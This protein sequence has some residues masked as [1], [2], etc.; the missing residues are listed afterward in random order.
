MRD[1]KK[2]GLR[3]AVALLVIFSL[4][5]IIPRAMPGDP[6]IYLVG[7]DA[8]LDSSTMM[9]L[10][11][12]LGLDKPLW[13]QYLDYWRQVLQLDFGYSYHFK[14]KVSQVILKRIPWTLGLLLPPL[15][16]G[17]ILGTVLGGLSG[18]R[19]NNWLNKSLTGCSLAI[20]STP[21][22]FLALLLLYLFSIHWEIFPLKGFY[23]TGTF[24]DLLGHYFLPVLV[25]TLFTASRNF[26]IM[27]GSVLR[28]K[29]QWYVLYARA[30]GLSGN[31]LFFRH[32][33]RNAVLPAITMIALD[34]GFLLS[35]ALLVEIVFSM[36][37]MGTLI[38]EA[39]LSR[40]YPLLQGIF[41]VITLMVV[42]ANLAADLLYRRLDPRLQNQ[43]P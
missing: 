24:F 13:R 1:L 8:L 19:K 31:R 12:Q 20:Y 2:K 43:E 33:F 40:D 22:Y 5:F 35:G 16:L 41:L 28:E 23:R 14:Q 11:S 3:I 34:F 36:N 18:W 4:N 9:E 25:M 37:G 26:L 42:F 10:R 38:F 21:P 15:L 27:R 39:L 30:K 29:H 7:E 17:A 32:V 6:L